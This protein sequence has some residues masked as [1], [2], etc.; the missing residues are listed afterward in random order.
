[1]A[2]QTATFMADFL[3]AR[4]NNRLPLTPY[5]FVILQ[6]GRDIDRVNALTEIGTG[7]H[8][9]IFSRADVITIRIENV[10]D[11]KESYSQLNTIVYANPDSYT[12]EAAGNDSVTSAENY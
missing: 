6:N 2:D 7:I 8:K 3:D 5:D 4:T 10:G 1:M 12:S 9:Y 11:N